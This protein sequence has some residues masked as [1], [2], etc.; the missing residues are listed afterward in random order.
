MRRVRLGIAG[1]IILFG[2]GI[3]AVLTTRDGPDER[4]PARE[5]TAKPSAPSASAQPAGSNSPIRFVLADEYTVGETV[6]V[7][8][9]N[10]GR[11]AYVYE[12]MYQACFLSYFD[13]SGRRFTIPPGTHCDILAKA[14]IKPGER[15]KLF[16]WRLDE[17]VKDQWGCLKSRPLPP[18]TYTIRG[19]FAPK[20]SGVPARVQTTFE[21]AA[22]EHPL[23]LI[24][25]APRTRL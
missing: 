17:C 9:E 1:I 18:G 2:G 4:G 6:R 7:V 12:S 20:A 11:R 24:Q 25:A 14:V 19:R 13:A 10:V 15:R 23:P 21:I 22:A 8:I 5:R 16:S 3:L